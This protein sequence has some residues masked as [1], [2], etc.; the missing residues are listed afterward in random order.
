MK[1]ETQEA[2]D[3]RA[4]SA[5]EGFE[6]IRPVRHWRA[7]AVA[8][9][10]DADIFSIE[11][12]RGDGRP[13][14]KTAYIPN[15]EKV[16]LILA[17]R[18]DSKGAF[19]SCSRARLKELSLLASLWARMR[20][21]WLKKKNILDFGEFRVFIGGP[22]PSRR[23]LISAIKYLRKLGTPLDGETIQRRPELLLGWGPNGVS[24]PVR[25]SERHKTTA[26]VAVVLHLFY[27]DLWP[28]ILA[29]LRSLPLAFDL[30]VTTVADRTAL[31]EAIR[32]DF[33]TATI[34]VV[35]NRGRDVRPFLL[36]L[37]EGALDGYD[38]V[39]KIHGKK[40]LHGLKRSPYGE[41]WRR[42]LLFDL[43]GA[44]RT[45]ATAIQQFERDPDL[46]LVGPEV[47]RVEGVEITEFYWRKNWKFVSQL[48]HRLGADPARIV[49]DFFAGTMFWVRPKAL[50]PLRDLRLAEEFEADQGKTDGSLEH[51]VERVLSIVVMRAGYK[52]SDINGLRV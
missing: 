36:L 8:P 13:A 39:C 50:A 11:H 30:I 48:L 9:D 12:M 45:M 52:I 51:A 2:R 28:E 15:I 21:L 16:T 19:L 5:A 37:E 33:P 46:G 27:A 40:S 14:R 31:I 41:I 4:A 44:D 7:Y 25:R 38:C 23:V 17:P 1:A 3:L 49:P 32:L 47:F 43:L 20:S 34:R 35:E 29:V 10:T 6:T 18:S 22:K 24:L 26:K 42:R